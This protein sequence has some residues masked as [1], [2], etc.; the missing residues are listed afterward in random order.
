MLRPKLLF[1]IVIIFFGTCSQGAASPAEV[2]YN[3][4]YW[5]SIPHLLNQ[6][7]NF[8]HAKDAQTGDP[9]AEFVGDADNPG[10]YFMYESDTNGGLNPDGRLLFRVRVAAYQ[11]TKNT[12]PTNAPGEYGSSVFVGIDGN[13]DGA[14]DIFVVADDRGS[15]ASNGVK[16]YFPSCPSSG[17]G[18]CFTGPSKTNLGNQYGSNTLFTST[19]SNQNFN[20]VEVNSTT[21][22]RSGSQPPLDNNITAGTEGNNSSYDNPDGFFSFAVDF[23]FLANALADSGAHTGT[24]PPTV[25][26]NFTP[27]STM[28]FMTVTA[29]QTNSFNQD[30][31]GCNNNNTVVS[32]GCAFSDPLTPL[33]YI[34]TPEPASFAFVGCG[35]AGIFATRRR[36]R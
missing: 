10:F 9:R 1:I 33:D 5:Y 16:L 35:L 26:N 24:N 28:R 4:S 11:S 27:S 36:R 3:T 17:S 31:G 15:A 2:W 29:Q 6:S 13:S 12:I 19:G 22:P 14:I 30:T 23:R 25:I 7:Y 8:D 21:D 34:P 32:W 20:W 18:T